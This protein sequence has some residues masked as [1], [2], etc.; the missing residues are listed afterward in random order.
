M[1]AIVAVNNEWGIGLN[2]SLLCNIPGDLSRFKQLTTDGIVVMGS[3][4]WDSLPKKPLPN[5]TNIIITRDVTKY[6]EY[7]T[8]YTAIIRNEFTLGRTYAADI[9]DVSVLNLSEYSDKVWIIGGG[10]I[11]T[12]CIGQCDTVEL[13]QIINPLEADTFI[14]NLYNL[15]FH[16]VFRTDLIEENGY[17]YRFIK[18]KK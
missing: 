13:T 3:K 14:P 2:G 17:M 16:E 5:R 7:P 1:K 9:E 10:E 8:L 6:P 12:Q 15:G 4:T 18:L 11:Y